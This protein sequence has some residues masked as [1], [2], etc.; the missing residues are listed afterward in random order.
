MFSKSLIQFSVDEPGCVPFLLLDLRPNYGGGNE[1]NGVLLQRD[2]CRYIIAQIIRNV[3]RFFA[4]MPFPALPINGFNF[5]CL[6]RMRLNS[7]TK[8]TPEVVAIMNAM[9]PRAKILM[10]G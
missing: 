9:N 10:A 2:P 6:G 8:S 4:R 7:F 1:D 5:L 3:N